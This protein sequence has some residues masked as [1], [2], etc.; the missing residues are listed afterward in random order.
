VNYDLHTHSVRSGDGLSTIRELV[1][2]AKIRSVKTLAVTDHGFGM[3]DGPHPSYFVAAKRIPPII[4]GV[5]IMFG[6]EANILNKN[7]KIDV[8]DNTLSLLDI[9]LVGLHDLTA[10]EG[11]TVANNTAAIISAMNNTW[12]DVVAH[13]YRVSFKTDIDE[14]FKE[15]MR[16]GVL[17]EINISVLRDCS[18][19]EMRAYK[20]IQ[21][22][23]CLYAY[24]VS[25]GTDAHIFSEVGDDCALK[26]AGFCLQYNIFEYGN[27]RIVK[28]TKENNKNAFYNIF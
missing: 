19:D 5:N 24:P 22:L 28:K 15:A 6:C 13:P 14:I 20:R 3:V 10:Y 18:V 21:E 11:N 9:V 23:S 12:V 7:G 2:A 16:R 27:L 17:L 25:V 26:K 1:Q 4:D 8:D